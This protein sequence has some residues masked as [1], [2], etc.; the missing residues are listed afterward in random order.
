MAGSALLIK[1][2]SELISLPTFEER[3]R[4][5]LL[6]DL[7]PSM[8]V[9]GGM[10]WVNQA[11]YHSQEWKNFR[12][13]IILRDCGNELAFEGRPIEGKVI[14]HHLNALRVEDFE[15]NTSKIWDPENVISVSLDMHNFI[16][17][18]KNVGVPKHDY[19]PRQPNDTIP[20]R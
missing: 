20:W 4:Y 7:S 16:H 19:V 3:V 5:V 2:Y 12:R 14:I 8:I 13:D 1:T 10:R 17:F 11:L 15:K 6:R 18:G 9:F